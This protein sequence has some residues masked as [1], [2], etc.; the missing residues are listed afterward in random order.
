MDVE[1]ATAQG[2]HVQE[3]IDFIGTRELDVWHCLTTTCGEW[4]FVERN[5]NTM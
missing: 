5:W 4:G 1:D 3:A 2:A